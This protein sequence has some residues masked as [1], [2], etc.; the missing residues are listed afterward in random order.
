MQAVK[1]PEPGCDKTTAQHIADFKAL[2]M[3]FHTKNL[4]MRERLSR[5]APMEIDS[6][7]T[8]EERQKKATEA[9]I[10]FKKHLAER[11]EEVPF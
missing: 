2:V 4:R 9:L 10:A 8:P 1:C 6:G 7:L 3:A 11:Q 5:P